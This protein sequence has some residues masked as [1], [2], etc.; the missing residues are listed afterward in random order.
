[1][2]ISIGEQLPA[3]T[4]SEYIEVE[5]EGCS[6]G[7]QSIQV[8]DAVKGKTIALFGVPGAFT[9]TCSAQ[10]VPGYV[11]LAQEL[12]AKGVDE[13]WCVSVNDA[14]VMGAWGREQKSTGLVRMM[15]DGSATF[16]R[17]LGLELD[18]TTRN[19]GIRSR[20]YS[21]LVVD[22]VVKQLNLEQGG[23][24]EVSN[25]ETMLEQLG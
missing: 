11:K 16:T 6:A 22:G 4:L 18:L 24:F 21:A 9:P 13:I 15:G 19:M 3:A 20:R 7:P 8:Q 17:A 5:T 23:K 12:K 25:A 2:A 14:F 1:M 10:H